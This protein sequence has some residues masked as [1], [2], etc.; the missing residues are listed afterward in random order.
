M[1]SWLAS[2]FELVILFFAALN[3]GAIGL[4]RRRDRKLKETQ[5]LCKAQAK[6]I[7]MLTRDYTQVLEFNFQD[8]YTIRELAMMVSGFRSQLNLPQI[9][10]LLMLYQKAELEMKARQ[11]SAQ[12]ESGFH[13][14]FQGADDSL[15]EDSL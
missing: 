6:K 4:N 5:E 8:R 12:H 2:H 14:T 9:D 13:R 10:I 11:L 15:T 1:T 7:K 3:G